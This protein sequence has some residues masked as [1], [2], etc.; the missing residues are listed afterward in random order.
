MDILEALSD[1][2]QK[3]DHQEIFRK[4]VTTLRSYKNLTE[5]EIA[6]VESLLW[7]CLEFNE[8]L[9][10]FKE[11]PNNWINPFKFMLE[12]YSESDMRKMVLKEST[13]KVIQDT[14]AQEFGVICEIP[15]M[16]G[17]FYTVKRQDLNLCD[18]PI[19]CTKIFAL[20]IERSDK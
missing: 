15:E 4:W 6:H 12:N 7:I 14:E 19:G 8:L 2:F 17:H 16:G 11:S 13:K 9:G 5:E 3:R 10:P 18:L 1:L 20:K